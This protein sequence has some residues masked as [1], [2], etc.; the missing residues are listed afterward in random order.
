SPGLTGR[1]LDV[2]AAARVGTDHECTTPE[3]ALERIR[4][5]MYVILRAGSAARDLLR[6]LPAVDPMNARRCLFCTD[7]RQPVDI[8][9]RGHIDGHLRMAVAAGLD[10]VTAVRMATLNA[11]ECYGLRDKGGIAPGR[12]ADLALVGD[13]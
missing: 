8:L 3:E 5:G 4:R 1:E 2:Y 13:L 6:L 11:A 12:R 9:E 7:D 10:P